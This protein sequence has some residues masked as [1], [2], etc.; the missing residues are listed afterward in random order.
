MKDKIKKILQTIYL[1]EYEYERLIAILT[2]ELRYTLQLLIY[3]YKLQVQMIKDKNTH[4]SDLDQITRD[5]NYVISE[6]VNYIHRN[7][8]TTMNKNEIKRL[9]LNIIK[10]L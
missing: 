3:L 9:I 5:F 2:E 4:R 7:M 8:I 10:E 1:S 6:I